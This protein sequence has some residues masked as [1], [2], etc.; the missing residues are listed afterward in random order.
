M[1]EPSTISTGV[2]HSR[3]KSAPNH[4]RRSS[5]AGA[6]EMTLSNSPV[7]MFEARVQAESNEKFVL[8][9]PAFSGLTR[10]P[11]PDEAPQIV[12]DDYPPG[13]SV[14]GNVSEPL[15]DPEDLDGL[16][17]GC[18]RNAVSCLRLRRQRQL[19]EHARSSLAPEHGIHAPANALWDIIHSV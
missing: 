12:V 2:R 16:S 6:D 7:F 10:R 17:T 15:E 8:L 3:A 18:L 4:A 1:A 11:L 14:L 5:G 19:F 13:G 9:R